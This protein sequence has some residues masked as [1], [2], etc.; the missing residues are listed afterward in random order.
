MRKISNNAS[1]LTLNDID[2]EAGAGPVTLTFAVDNSQGQLALFPDVDTIAA[3]YAYCTLENV[4]G[5]VEICKLNSVNVVSGTV[6]VARGNGAFP[7]GHLD[8]PAAVGGMKAFPA[9][10]RFECRPTAGLFNSFLQRDGDTIH[11]GI[12][13]APGLTPEPAESVRIITRHTFDPNTA[14]PLAPNMLI[15]EFYFNAKTKKLIVGAVDAA[16]A[17]ERWELVPGI[18]YG[19]A[20]PEEYQKTVRTLWYQTT[21]EVGAETFTRN[22]LKLWN[23]TAWVPVI[24]FAH[25]TSDLI[26]DNDKALQGRHSNGTTIYN[27]A[28]VNTVN[29]VL[30]GASGAALTRLLGAAV[31]V[32]SPFRVKQNAAA[33]SWWTLSASAPAGSPRLIIQ[34]TL[35]GLVAADMQFRTFESD[36][37]V[38]DTYVL[39]TGLVRVSNLVP[40][41]PGD[42]VPL[43][44]LEDALAGL[45]P[46]GGI[47]AAG[48]VSA[49]G[50]ASGPLF[51]CTVSGGAGV[52]TITLANNAT[53]PVLTAT[54]VG[55]GNT[56]VADFCWSFA[57]PKT[58]TVRTFTAGSQTDPVARAFSFHVVET[59]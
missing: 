13:G 24:S 53:N 32:E 25:L 19:S 57:G 10:S 48:N 54:A 9:G 59:G 22:T 2:A 15:G 23:G 20:E 35:P 45:T 52:Y 4:D 40:A 51:G 38:H 1:T 16:D 18:Y 12:F 49:G 41:A 50:A 58:I 6:T 27:L 7:A 14:G 56:Q 44:F 3:D 43:A 39:S 47:V 30:L 31:Q 33:T 29:E 28:K 5:E 17:L 11:G 46:T 37:T 36:G 8:A 34:P 26:L 21:E 42:L 55:T